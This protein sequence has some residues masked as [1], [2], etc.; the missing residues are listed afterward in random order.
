MMKSC[1]HLRSRDQA[2]LKAIMIRWN[3][4]IM[5]P[6]MSNSKLQNGQRSNQTEEYY[7]RI[8]TLKLPGLR[9]FT[10]KFVFRTYPGKTSFILDG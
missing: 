2:R 1:D 7:S 3:R 10:E 6:K 5:S 4:L 9:V 8:E